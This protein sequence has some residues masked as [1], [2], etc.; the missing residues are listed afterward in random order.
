MIT[1]PSTLAWLQPLSRPPPAQPGPNT[2]PIKTLHFTQ[3][4]TLQ[5]SCSLWATWQELRLQGVS[6]DLEVTS[7]VVKSMRSLTKIATFREQAHD[8]RYSPHPLQLLH[9][10][11]SIALRGDFT[12]LRESWEKRGGVIDEA[13]EQRILGECRCADENVVVEEVH[14]MRKRALKAQL[15]QWLLERPMRRGKSIDLWQEQENSICDPQSN[16]Q[17]AS[18]GEHYCSSVC[19]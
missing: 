7:D 18:M 12:F 13:V 16:I 9:T 8:E 4:C 17:R 10:Y 2:A 19:G 1:S 11:R 5:H 15:Q 6:V 14:R 3:T